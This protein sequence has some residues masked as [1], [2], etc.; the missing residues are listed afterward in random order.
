M[1][2]HKDTKNTK[3][4]DKEDKEGSC[5][6]QPGG[7]ALAC[8]AVVLPLVMSS[9][10]PLCLCGESDSPKKL[11][12]AAWGGDHVGKPVPEF[13]GGD[14]CLFCH[15][16]DVGPTWGKNRHNLTLRPGDGEGRFV[17]GHGQRERS[18]KRGEKAGTLELLTPEGKWDAKAFG[19]GCA[20]CHST[21][22]NAKSRAFT[23]VSLDCFVCH[24]E[25]PDKHTQDGSLVF[26]AP[27]KKDSARV[28]TSACAQCHIRSG[29]AKSTG[30]PYPNN[31]VAGDNLFRDFQV[32]LSDEAIKKLNPADAHVL[33]NVRDVVLF[34]KEE[35]TCQSC[36]DVHKQSSTKHH[37]VAESEACLDCHNPTGSKKDRPPF[38]VHGKVCGY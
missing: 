34:G 15:R 27:K 11:D 22:V 19:D 18:L 29:T 6:V 1:V 14:E 10:C 33:H 3:K 35:V 16:M 20:G 23:A 7:L 12:P 13:T 8:L 9:L 2:H 38:E 25:V 30:L 17:L 31:F 37:R 21:G 28:V 4:E 32:D 36:H 26:L 24:G 5:R